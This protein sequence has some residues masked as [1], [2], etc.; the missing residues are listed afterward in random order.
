[1]SEHTQPR[2]RGLHS[3]A[4]AA[5]GARLNILANSKGREHAALAWL[6][7]LSHTPW[8]CL[9]RPTWATNETLAAETGLELVDTERALQR[10]REAGMLTTPWGHRPGAQ[11]KFGRLLVPALGAPAVV[12]IPDRHDMTNLWALCR[13]KRK[14]PAPLVTMV[15]G[16]YAL[17]C[18]HAGERFDEWAPIGCRQADW[19]RF[20]GARK[21]ASWSE[22]VR[23]LEALDLIRR[24]GRAIE[25]APTRSWLRAA[26][27]LDL[28]ADSTGPPLAA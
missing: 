26:R 14:R 7:I 16:A 24:K 25:V 5:V 18:D 8:E 11:R 4:T 15:V 28:F 3:H 6:A 22:R 9:T 19:R 1:M 17:A 21:N 20:V 27:A 10:L 2:A 23:V 12:L 13:E